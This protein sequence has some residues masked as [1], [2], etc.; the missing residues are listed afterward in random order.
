MNITRVASVTENCE[1]HICEY[2]PTYKFQNGRRDFDRY[3]ETAD[4]VTTFADYIAR[5][6]ECEQ[7]GVS[8]E[9]SAIGDTHALDVF[10]H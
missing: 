2:M 9:A 4:Y 6:I 8:Y 7:T 1:Y 10:L 3:V 5:I